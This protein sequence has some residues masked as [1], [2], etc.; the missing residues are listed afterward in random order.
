MEA[1]R[2]LRYSIQYAQSLIAMYSLVPVE[3]VERQVVHNKYMKPFRNHLT[4]ARDK[5]LALVQKLRAFVDSV[6]GLNS[7]TF[8]TPLLQGLSSYISDA[9]EAALVNGANIEHTIGLLAD[10]VI[11]PGLDYSSHPKTLPF[12]PEARKRV[13]M[14]V[15]LRKAAARPLTYLNASDRNRVTIALRKSSGII[16][17]AR[18]RKE[19]NDN[20][21]DDDDDDGDSMEEGGSPI[22]S[23]SSR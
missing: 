3:V 17:K 6:A 19:N 18:E 11:A 13:S 23:L 5:L 12:V 20:D 9:R 14:V 22:H 16:L 2:L 15:V 4:S 10:E 7:Q 8:L 1:D 21:D